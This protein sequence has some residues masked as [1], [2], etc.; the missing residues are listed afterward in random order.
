M[1]ALSITFNSPEIPIIPVKFLS[2]SIGGFA[3]IDETNF[4]NN[5]KKK[6]KKASSN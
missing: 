5:K 4:S 3:T 2:V 6:F 1:P